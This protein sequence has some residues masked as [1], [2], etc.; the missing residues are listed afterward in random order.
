MNKKL[1]MKKLLLPSLIF[2]LAA[3]NASA[4]G[5]VNLWSVA[6]SSKDYKASEV[7][8]YFTNNDKDGLLVNGDFASGKTL[9]MDANLTLAELRMQNDDWTVDFNNSNHTLTVNSLTKQNLETGKKDTSSFVTSVRFINS[10]KDGCLVFNAPT[11]HRLTFKNTDTTV[12]R[13]WN[14][15]ELEGT[16]H[17]TGDIS[18]EEGNNVHI[19][20]LQ[21]NA[22]DISV[23]KGLFEIDNLTTATDVLGLGGGITA[24]NG[25]TVKIT[26]S[27]RMYGGQTI[28]ASG[29]S[30]VTV[31]FNGTGTANEYWASNITAND[32]DTMVTLKF[33]HGTYGTSVVVGNGAT[34]N[35]TNTTKKSELVTQLN[36]GATFNFATTA[37]DDKAGIWIERPSS[38]YYWGLGGTAV[39]NVSVDGVIYVHSGANL[40]IG[41]N[42]I[43]KNNDGIR[44]EKGKVE[45][46][47]NNK[48]TN[49]AGTATQGNSLK[50]IFLGDKVATLS[51]GA[52]NDVNTIT[53]QNAANGIVDLN[54][55][56]FSFV[57]LVD[58]G[59]QL[60]LED[61]VNDK[62]SYRG[63]EKLSS[64]VVTGALSNIFGYD[65]ATGDYTSL[66]LT[67]VSDGNGGFYLSSISPA[68][69]EPA[70]WA[71]ILGGVALAFAVYRRR[72]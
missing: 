62:V 42:T 25:A 27:N 56:K 19:K 37:V 53:L 69:P 65:S 55:N 8:T 13:Y 3:S 14:M 41:S 6:S 2:A 67:N 46:N 16:V 43:V 40:R 7:N 11:F 28:N 35:Y 50:V 15:D 68:V 32:A 45:L 21:K 44:L 47:G 33:A 49:L 51:L 66:Y 20:N 72:K 34:V 10:T 30:D 4:A 52:D 64:D 60:L 9:T 70:E 61:F 59:G 71:A 18:V 58:N 63:T 36:D 26:T 5:V 39:T 57:N 54:G 22:G 1:H 23:D 17:M 31:N 24:K 29:G 48:F 38:S 12:Q